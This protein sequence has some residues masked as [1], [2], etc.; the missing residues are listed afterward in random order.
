MCAVSRIGAC[1]TGS[2]AIRLII[3]C[4]LLVIF[5][6]VRP[7]HS[8]IDMKLVQLDT[9]AAKVG[10]TAEFLVDNFYRNASALVMWGS[11]L[12]I[13]RKVRT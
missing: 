1:S 7:W 6:L 4:V 8:H 5:R 2:L 12:G 11:A 10:D 9:G 13:E 3:F